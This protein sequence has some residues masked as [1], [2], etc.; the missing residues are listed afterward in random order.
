MQAQMTSTAG[1]NHLASSRARKQRQHLSSTF[2]GLLLFVLVYGA[3]Q[4]MQQL[5]WVTPLFDRTLL[6]CLLPYGLAAYLLYH[7][8]YMPSDE[9]RIMVLIHSSLPYLLLV[10]CFALLQYDYARSPVLISAVLTTGLFW[11]RHKLANTEL[12]LLILDS[13]CQTRLES[14]LDNPKAKSSFAIEFLRWPAGQIEPPD[15]DGALVSDK[16]V[17]NA[18]QQALL[19]QLKLKHVRIYSVAA[20]A[21]PLTGRKSPDELNNLLWQPDGNPAYDVFKRLADLWVVLLLAPMWVPLGMLVALAI[22]LDSKGPVFFTQIRTGL[23]G[24]PFR[25]WKFRTMVPQDTHIAQFAGKNDRRITR[26]GRFLRK[27]RLDEIPQLYNVLRGNMSLIGPRPEQHAFVQDFAITIP[28]YPYR[29]LVRPGLT[30][31]AQVMQGYAANE[32]ET[33]VKLSYDLYYVS[34]YSLA[35]DLLIVAK[36]IKTILTGFGAR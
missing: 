32:E 4:V 12:K 21:E 6:W 11:W 20:V 31:W 13:E 1:Q 26:L 7:T 3:G 35:V 10:L 9:Q 19:T 33:S 15:C 14:Q 34:H 30:G 29:H 28:S 24:R 25:I 23:H 22:M 17:P 18:E 16:L 27:S 2:G 36:T 5:G 8:A